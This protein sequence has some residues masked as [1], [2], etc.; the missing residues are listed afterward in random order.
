M[1]DFQVLPAEG[2]YAF[3]VDFTDVMS[4]GVTLVSVAWSASPTLTLTGQSDD[5][6]NNRS[7]IVAAGSTHA[8]SYLLQAK[9]TASNGEIYPKDVALI[10]FN[11]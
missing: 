6:A 1:N 10:G 11:G 9:A 8:A 3:T 2:K 7:T 4:S 5:F